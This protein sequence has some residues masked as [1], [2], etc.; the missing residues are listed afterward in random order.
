MATGQAER[1]FALLEAALCDAGKTWDQLSAIAVATGP[2]NFT[3]VRIAVSAARGLAL[4]LEIPAIGVSVLQA[5][6]RP[7]KGPSLI[8]LDARR[9]RLFAQYFK[10]GVPQSEAEL[11]SWQ[12]LT[13][14]Q[15]NSEICC[16]G[17]RCEDVAAALGAHTGGEQVT[18]DPVEIAL[19]A[20]EFP[21]AQRPAPVYLRSPDAA[22]PS[23][24]P[25]TILHET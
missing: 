15:H 2:G 20:M 11:V 23:D 24:P 6:A 3:G 7:V 25:P 22:L 19:C 5:L 21:D 4:A 13:S 16:V 10:D 12:A 18:A 9:D 17:Y 1:L 8:T 14:R